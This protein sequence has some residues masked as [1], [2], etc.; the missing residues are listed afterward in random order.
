MLDILKTYSSSKSEKAQPIPDKGELQK[1]LKSFTKPERITEEEV[2]ISKEKKTCL[3]CKN[4]VG[5][6]NFICSECGAFYCQNCAQTL[7]GM[8]NACWVCEAPFDKSKPQ[9]K[10]KIEDE[11]EELEEL[12]HKKGDKI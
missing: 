11:I 7:T 5:G 8:E 4:K 2:S 12:I 9:K 1:I 6:Y 10:D 3:V